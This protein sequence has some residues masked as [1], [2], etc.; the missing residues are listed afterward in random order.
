MYWN[1][2]YRKSW[3]PG[4]G[5]GGAPSGNPPMHIKWIQQ[6]E[7]IIHYFLIKVR[8]SVC[9]YHCLG[10]LYIPPVLFPC[11]VVNNH[12]YEFGLWIFCSVLLA[13]ALLYGS[14]KTM[15]SVATGTVEVLTYYIPDIGKTLTVIF[16]VPFNY[17]LYSNWFD[18][19]GFTVAK[20]VQLQLATVFGKSCITMIPSKGI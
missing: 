16:S 8:V 18:V 7:R 3:N 12:V 6:T 5:G 9:L 15:G 19:S 1:P 10:F 14:Q 20:S 2:E 4:G 17:N 13:T 11:A